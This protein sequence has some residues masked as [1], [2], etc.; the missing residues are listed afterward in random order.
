MSQRP[1]T[2]GEK[3]TVEPL[4]RG[5]LQLHCLVLALLV[6]TS[7]SAGKLD[8]VRDATDDGSGGSGNDASGDSSGDDSGDDSGDGLAEAVGAAFMDAIAAAAAER[9]GRVRFAPYPY[10]EGH[11]GWVVPEPTADDEAATAP[12]GP[13]V[14]PRVSFRFS[15][16]DAY[17]WERVHRP[18]IVLALDTSSGV[19]LRADYTNY[20]E[21]LPAGRLDY[22]GIGTLDAMFRM[23]DARRAALYLGLGWRYLVDP[24]ARGAALVNGFNSL[25]SLDVFPVRPIVLSAIAEG[26][27]LGAAG[28][29]HGRLT[30]GAL[31]QRLEIFA[32]YDA[33]VFGTGDE[34]PIV[35]HGPVVGIRGWL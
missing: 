15:L 16:D 3:N 30:F 11:G 24:S 19:G 27:N 5:S 21:R 8:D 18:A 32:G 22:L 26:G 33:V 7:A 17:A 14:L 34:N 10:A 1:H 13:A 12:E 29:F 4:G 6:S 25:L 35:F 28:F 9:A 23:L 31:V 20:V 2:C